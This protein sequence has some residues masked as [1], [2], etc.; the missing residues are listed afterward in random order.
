[1]IVVDHE[2]PVDDRL[3]LPAG[4]PAALPAPPASGA[5]ARWVYYSSGTTA[6]PKGAR[7][8]D[9]SV[10][11]GST[12]VISMIGASSSDVNPIAFP[13]SHIGGAAMLV[14]FD[15]FDPAIT[16]KAIAAHR[17]TLLGTA[18]P[19]LVAFLAAQAEHGD[20]PLFPDLRGCVGG[21]A[22]I[23]AE[24]AR[25]VRETFSVPGVA[26][27][28]GLTEFPVATSQTPDAAP[29]LLDHTVGRA[30]PGVTVRVVDDA[31][32]EVAAGCE[33]ELRLK[34]PQCFSGYVDTS[35]NADAFDADG[36]FRTG[37]RGRIDAQGNVTVTGRI[38]DAIIRNAENISAMEIEEVLAS[39]PGV[40]DV[41]VIGVPDERTGERV[42][43]VV[44]GGDDLTLA[45]L[46][47]HC[48]ARGLSKHKSPERL[49]IVDA[50]PRNLTGKVLKHE[51]RVRYA[52]S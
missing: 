45:S 43:A 4:D 12:G 19:F 51:L 49:E 31:E 30:V 6:A 14:L 37:D 48:Q 8:S 7:H 28:W 33:G 15:N 20:D 3:R 10:I 16:P 47:D 35:L 1:V 44:V 13:V 29:H 39:H 17:P 46:F 32:N 42:C 9:R 21:G 41:A 22:P 50:L 5:Q 2:L 23:T 11:A 25:R 18:T 36:W 26:N 40:V 38:K 27:A 24:L 34:G 52:N